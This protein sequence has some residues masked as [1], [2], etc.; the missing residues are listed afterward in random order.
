M[1]LGIDLG[2]SGVKAVLIG[3]DQTPIGQANVA[4][5]LSRPRPNFSEQDP[6]DWWRAVCGAIQT[7]Q[8]QTPQE[9]AAV[10]GIGR[11]RQMRGAPPLD[12]APKALRPALLVTDGIPLA[13]PAD[14]GAGGQ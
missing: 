3:E 9:S 8:V 7:L 1:Y 13:R 5:D 12:A 10:P 2:T 14:A 6:A 11:S 4:L